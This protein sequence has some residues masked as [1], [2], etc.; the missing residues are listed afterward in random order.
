LKDFIAKKKTMV[1]KNAQRQ[2]AKEIF[3]ISVSCDRKLGW[4]HVGLYS[5]SVLVCYSWHILLRHTILRFTDGFT[6]KKGKDPARPARISI[7]IIKA[8]CV[9]NLMRGLVCYKEITVS[10]IEWLYKKWNIVELVWFR[11]YSGNMRA[12]FKS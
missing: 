5:A 9:T 3:P 1:V 4:W 8:Y 2:A 10:R 11:W 7:D 6:V 12:E